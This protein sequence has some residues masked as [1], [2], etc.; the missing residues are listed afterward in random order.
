MDEPRGRVQSITP[1]QLARLFERIRE[2]LP[3]YEFNESITPF[4]S[5]YDNWHVFGRRRNKSALRKTSAASDSRPGSTRTRSDYDGDDTSTADSERER[6]QW[7][8]GR[9]SKHSLRLEREYRICETL[10][11]ESDPEY[12]HFVKPLQFARL[13]P[14]KDGDKPLVM[15]VV[16]APGKNYLRELVEFGPNFYQGSRADGKPDNGIRMA[17]GPPE[18]IQI[19][20]LLFLDFAI[21]ATECC[22][23]LHHGN[24]IVHGELRGDAFHYNRDTGRVKMINFGSGVRSFEHGL[25]SAGWS[26]LMSELGVEH[27]LQFIAPEQTGRLPAEPDSRTDIYSLGILFWTMLTGKPAF[28]GKTPLDIMQ[29]VLSRRVPTASSVRPDVPD[30]L[31]AV[32]Q[33]MTQKNMDE[34]Y[35]STSGVKHDLVELKRILTDGDREALGTFKMATRD[36]SCFFNLPSHLVGREE[37][38]KTIIRV[39]ET[40]ADRLE[41]AAPVTKKGLYSLSS[42]S[43]MLSGD[44][45]DQVH[46]DDLMSDSTSSGDPRDTRLNSISEAAP[47]DLSKMHH[48]SQENISSSGQSGNEESSSLNIRPLHPQI[49]LDSR[50]SLNSGDGVLCSSNSFQSVEMP[51]SLLRTAQKLKKSGKTEIIAISG[52]AGFGKS[53]LVA[54]IQATARSHGYFTGA[55]FDAVKR[56]PYDPLL[57]VMSSLFRQIFSSHD[58]NTEF[59][60][61]IR[62][63]VKP[64]WG[65][66]HAYL[67]LPIW[68]LSPTINTKAG[69]HT[70]N[71]T[72][73]N[74]TQHA[75]PERRRCNGQTAQD[76]LRSGGSNKSSRFMHIFL[77][78]LRLLA[79]QK[80]ICFCLDDLQFADQESMDLLHNIVAA[81]IP[82]VLI[83][84]YRADS[85]LPNQLKLLIDAKATKVEV[86]PL[87]EAETAEYVSMTLH[88]PKE[89]CL[90]LSAVVLERTHGNPFFMRDMLDQCYRKKCIY[91]CWKCS[92]WEFDLDKTFNEFSSPDSDRFC[93]NDFIV[94]RLLDLPLDTRALLA[95]AGIIGNTFSYEL[96]KLVMACDCSRA[97]PKEF[98]PPNTTDA[99]AGL[100]GALSSF[101]IVATDNEDHFRF[102]HDRYLSAA[103]SL[104]NAFRREEMHFVISQALM[105]HDPYDPVTKPNKDLFDQAQHVCAC[106][107]VVKNRVAVRAPFRDLLYQAAEMARETGA[108][109]VGLYYFKHCLDL[110]QDDPWDESGPDSRY[111]ETLTL[112]TKAAEAYWYAGLFEEAERCISEIYK[113]ARDASD[114]APAA[115]I[116]SRMFAQRGDAGTA[117]ICLKRALSDLG[118][119]VPSTTYEECDD[120]FRRI[121]PLLK[122]SR[123]EALASHEIPVVDRDLMTLGAVLVELLSASFWS[124]ALLFYQG[125]LKMLN[126]YLERG[127]FPQV[128]LGFVHLGSIAIY[129]FN[130]IDFGIEVGEVALQLFDTFDSESYTLGRGLTLHSLFIAHLKS[131]V[132]DIFP[133]LSRAHE[134]AVTAGDKI[135][136]LLNIGIMGAY[137]TWASHDYQETEAY[138]AS[139]SEEFPDWEQDVRG[140][141]FLMGVRQ[142]SRA[143]QGKTDTR[144]PAD[145]LSDSSHHGETYCTYLGAKANPERPLTIYKSYKL[146][147]LFRFGHVKEALEL[148]DAMLPTMDGIWCMRFAYCNFFYIAITIIATIREDPA[149][150]DREDLLQRVKTC[151]ERIQVIASAN[152]VNYLVWLKLIDAETSELNKQ[153]GSSLQLYEAAIDH[154]VLH[155]FISD[156]ALSYELYADFLIRK[157]A[158]RPA[159]GMVTDCI[160][161][162]RRLSAFGKAAHVSEKYSFLLFGTRSLATAEMGTQTEVIDTGNTTY[163]LEQNQIS[164]NAESSADRTEAWLAPNAQVGQQQQK[165][166]TAALQGGLSAV[167]LDMI[168]LASILESSQLL[169]SELQVDR[170]LSKLTEIIIESTGAELCGLIVEEE[171]VGWC[172]A[173][174][175]GRDGIYERKDAGVPLDQIEDTVAKQVTLYVLRFKETVFLRNVLDDERFANVPSAWLKKNPDGAS[176][177]ALPILHGDNVLLGSLYVQGAPN[178]FTERSITVLRLLVSQ[179]S[180][181]I[182]NALLFKQVQKV[183]ASNSSMVEIQKQALAQARDA[184]RKAKAAEAKAMEMVRLKEEAA[185]AKSM[186]LA[187]VSHELRTPLNGVIGMSE[188]LK[189]TQL[190]KE[191]EEHAD[192]IR[193]CADTLLS[194][195]NDILD[196]SKLEAGKMQMF[197]VPLSLTETIKEVVRA[198]SYTNIERGLKTIE[199][200]D[201]D[202]GLIV[203]GDPVRLHQILMNLLSNAYKFTSRGS[204]TVRAKIEQEDAESIQTTISV[205]DTGRS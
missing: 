133:A 104:C 63:F 51:G 62:Q 96:I 11:K 147:A 116:R 39:I 146:A 130:L 187:N 156:E 179:I 204:V 46:V 98:L 94:R 118:M 119:N 203:M 180:I 102:A 125:T 17:P 170:L 87:S 28:Q 141:A 65:V 138:I 172:I 10:C 4:H 175:G 113:H 91:Y 171:D 100:Q 21:G 53:S 9:I 90:P 194:V 12:K 198:L 5:S 40:S 184:E 182:A 186:F 159:R 41:Q 200:L 80:F 178:S 60:N 106:I 24:E 78:V 150:P 95:W 115:I 135:L 123:L 168:D 124:D 139:V 126:L 2:E 157:G 68:L 166:H 74:G 16:E 142:Y 202:P 44:R 58:V 50:G 66:L 144:L 122:D 163:R 155:G 103:D 120:E 36:V 181:S 140:G 158:A 70:P 127:I 35:N 152:D 27:K 75:A 99:V 33:K 52:N 26:S 117:F 131:E 192:S 3:A 54:S 47:P 197:S 121:T 72:T 165:E 196:F 85:V 69:H 105:K 32:I 112:L 97:S 14:R 136:H 134:A 151:R 109:S 190:S 73:Q 128:A 67:E 145:I 110:L 101:T 42:G 201:L 169:S 61:N 64:F 76:W 154:A 13:P 29:N 82:V 49:S 30:A 183:S 195:I 84:T 108:R 114:K 164:N 19:P 167:G 89:Y 48:L 22:E 162:Y 7:V 188:M 83:V 205:T 129:R 59:H 18:N 55:K 20:L 77:D 137:R 174:S 161:C 38:R 45:Q 185:K 132:R 107:A 199:Q 8:V 176:M 15:F 189:G 71:A 88:R 191:Q 37:Q 31:S 143:M 193:V 79:V 6:E 160:A 23:I 56:N 34:R 173:A 153:Y 1:A 149:R 81:R 93:T 25:T 177:I 43:S 86:G 148:A 92:H 57:R 111:S